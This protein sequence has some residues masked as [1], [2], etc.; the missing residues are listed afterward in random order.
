MLEH[1]PSYSYPGIG[2]GRLM[3]FMLGHSQVELVLKRWITS[4]FPVHILV[5][6]L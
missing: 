4:I 2:P 5:T 3:C 6:D 1:G